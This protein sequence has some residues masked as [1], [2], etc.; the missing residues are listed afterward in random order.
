MTMQCHS[1][2]NEMPMPMKCNANACPKQWQCK[3]KA[4]TMKKANVLTDFITHFRNP[5]TFFFYSQL[6]NLGGPKVDYFSG[7][8]RPE[9]LTIFLKS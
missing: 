8:N 7:S 2:C 3:A 5:Y 9:K 6:Q 4:K 1:E